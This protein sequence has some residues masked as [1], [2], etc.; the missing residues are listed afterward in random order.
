MPIAS[1]RSSFLVTAL[2]LCAP[3]LAAAATPAMP[4]TQTDVSF[5][6][7]NWRSLTADQPDSVRWGYTGLEF[8]L[9][10]GVRHRFDSG[11]TLA[12]DASAAPSFILGRST[13]SAGEWEEPRYAPSDR[14]FFGG[15]A[16]RVGWHSD[17][18][19]IEAGGAA[20]TF[21]TAA[22]LIGFDD[23]RRTLLPSGRAWAGKADLAYAFGQVVAGPLS[24]VNEGLLL[25]GVGH[26]SEWV[27]VDAGAWSGVGNL[28]FAV[29][30][31]PGVRIGADTTVAWGDEEA[32]RM[33][34]RGLLVISIEHARVG[35]GL[36]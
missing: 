10:V 13:L 36:Y 20:V 8:D 7:G 35:E 2:A 16:L 12:A 33:D 14:A 34:W 25:V 18:A 4:G 5:G 26:A 30:T 22:P 21:P 15:L 27:H 1:P 29:Q 6:A 23:A 9:A 3:G 19:G 32:E 28:R 24:S 17:Y 31:Q 11:L